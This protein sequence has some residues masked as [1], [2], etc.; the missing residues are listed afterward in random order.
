MYRF[1][2]LLTKLFSCVFPSELQRKRSHCPSAIKC[3]TGRRGCAAIENLL[4]AAL[5]FQ[6]ATPYQENVHTIPDKA[7]EPLVPK[8]SHLGVSLFH[9]IQLPLSAN[10]QHEELDRSPVTNRERP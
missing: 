2:V 10:Y 6:P 8:P 5:G 7:I 4:S 3:A 9:S 1:N